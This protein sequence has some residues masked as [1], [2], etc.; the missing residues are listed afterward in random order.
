M[1]MNLCPWG[2][3]GTSEG[4]E[5]PVL[6]ASKFQLSGGDEVPFWTSLKSGGSF[7]I[8]RTRTR[9]RMRTITRTTRRRGLL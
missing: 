9:M 3:S 4:M 5:G 2:N 8:K 1:N 7:K 6:V